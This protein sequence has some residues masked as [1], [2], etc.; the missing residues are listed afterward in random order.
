MSEPLDVLRAANVATSMLTA[1]LLY[2][3]L[4][5]L[6]RTFSPGLRI[7]M[8]GLFLMLLV[9]SYGTAESHLQNAPNGAR[10]PAIT[11]VCSLVLFGL[12]QS[13]HD[14]R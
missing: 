11:L 3:R 7:V 6:W 4:N 13:R 12:W 2:I 8:T 9:I 10:T 1:A 5:D 14:D